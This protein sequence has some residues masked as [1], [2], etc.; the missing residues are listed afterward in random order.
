[1]DTNLD[2]IL[3]NQQSSPTYYHSHHD[4]ARWQTN[5]YQHDK[6][7]SEANT[8]ASQLSSK[9]EIEPFQGCYYKKKDNISNHMIPDTSHNLINLKEEYADIESASLQ[10]FPKLQ[11]AY[12]HT[13]ESLNM[14]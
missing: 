3:S 5:V 9:S 8:K 1:M 4:R 12:P 11:I 7:Y 6:W 14:G 2:L 10:Q 13:L